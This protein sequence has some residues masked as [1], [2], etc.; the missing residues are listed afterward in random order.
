MDKPKRVAINF[1]GYNHRRYGKP[2]CAKVTAWEIG[3]APE[4]EW[5]GYLGDAS[6]GECELLALP[7]EVVRW[8]QKDHRGNNTTAHWGVVTPELTV[9]PVTA[10]EARQAYAK[11]QS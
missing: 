6:G 11:T 5:G 8:G 1:N 7:G 9:L 10:K 2:W 4:L 3:K